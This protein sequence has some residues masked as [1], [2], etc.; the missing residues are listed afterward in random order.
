MG[1][2]SSGFFGLTVKPPKKGQKKATVEPRF[3][4]VVDIDEAHAEVADVL[5]AWRS[6]SA[7]PDAP[8]FTGGVWDWPQR[9]AQGLAFLRAESA[10]VVAYLREEMIDG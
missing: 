6:T 3:K 5:A 8:P 9:V 4:A 7:W 2:Q 10:A 1:D